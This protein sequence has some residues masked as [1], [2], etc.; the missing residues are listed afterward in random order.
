MRATSG[1]QALSIPDVALTRGYST[2]GTLG[3]GYK[4]MISL[5]DR[6]YLETGPEGVTVAIEMMLEPASEQAL[7]PAR[8]LV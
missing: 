1:I 4:I 8:E 7:L 2:A 3:M 5:A 6:V